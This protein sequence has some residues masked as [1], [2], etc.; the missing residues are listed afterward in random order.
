MKVA[1]VVRQFFPSI[2]GLEDVVFNLA[3][4]QIKSGHTVKVFTINSDFQNNAQLANES[5]ESGISVT[6]YPW[7]GSERYP[8][9]L[10]PIGEL[11]CFDVVHVHAVDFFV[12]YLSLQKRLGRL[13]PLLVLTTHGGFFHT[14]KQAGL[15]KL[16]FKTI[17][18]FSLSKFDAVTCCS[19]NDYELFKNL[20]HNVSLIENGVGFQKL[21]KT[22]SEQKGN[23]FIY[24][25]RFSENKRIVELVELFAE[26]DCPDTRLKIIGRSKTGDVDA[27]RNKIIELG[28]TERV[29]LL[30]DINDQEILQHVAT[31]RFTV[32]ASAY[33]GFGLSVV[34]LMAYGLVPLLSAEPPSFKRFVEESGVGMQFTLDKSSLEQAIHHLTSQW[35]ESQGQSA[36]NYAKQ[37]AW[38]AVAEKYLN[39]Y[40]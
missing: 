4:E 6:R 17:T 14:N 1:H 9:C 7:H 33:E 13:K 12:E 24:F 22:Q 15:K 3:F 10:L 37:F 5:V 23:D 19:V 35:T 28:C 21:G 36:Q 30:T 11:N 25:G 16:F 20:N 8:V 27:I 40:Q 39:V 18:P 29:M 26:V 34:E 38:P 31:A 32:S 2:G